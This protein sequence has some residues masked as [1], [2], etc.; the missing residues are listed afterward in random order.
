[1]AGK[2]ALSPGSAGEFVGILGVAFQAR[3]HLSP[4]PLEWRSGSS[5]G[6]V[7]ARRRRSKAGSILRV[8]DFSRPRNVS[9]SAKRKSPSPCL[10]ARDERRRRRVRLRLRRAARR[11]WCGAGLLRRILR[12]PATESEVES[13]QRNGIV[14]DEPGFEAALRDDFLHRGGAGGEAILVGADML[15]FPRRAFPMARSDSSDCAA[16][17]ASGRGR[18]PM[19]TAGSR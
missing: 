1:M 19:A 13:D 7:T 8:S 12:G 6:A 3:D 15:W 4:H 11:A 9:L 17:D 16:A 10:R 2:G 14:F 18:L 5:R